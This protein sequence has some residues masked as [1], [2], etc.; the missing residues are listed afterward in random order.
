M[1]GGVIGLCLVTAAATGLTGGSALHAAL[2]VLV[3]ALTQVL[4]G[5]MIWRVVRA[6]DGWW[7]EDVTAG[8]AIGVALAVLAQSAAGT[9]SM[10]WLVWVVPAVVVLVLSAVP[11][12]RRRISTATTAALP[13]WIWPALGLVSLLGLPDIVR[14]F[15]RIPV[16]LNG[17]GATMYPDALFQVALS[18]ELL[19][20]GPTGWPMV[21]GEHLSYPWFTHAWTAQVSS[22][23]GLPLDQTL[24]RLLPI[25]SPLLA[26]GAAAALVLRLRGGPR[27]AVLAG[28]LTLM[29]GYANIFAVPGVA[30]SLNSMSPTLNLSVPLLLTLVAL[31]AQRWSGRA[32]PG[33]AVLVLVLGVVATGTKGSTTPLLIAGC[34]LALVAM[35]VVGRRN[36][37]RPI[38]VDAVLLT[39]SMLLTLKVLLRGSANGLT[40]NPMGASEAT[41]A[42]TMLSGPATLKTTVVV[43]VVTVVFLLAR[44]ATGLVCLLQPGTDRG[45]ADPI[46][47][48]LL[49]SVLAGIGAVLA[50]IQPGR[51]QLYFLINGH[52]LAAVLSALGAG[53]LMA[54]L[55]KDFSGR[56]AIIATTAVSGLALL[57]GPAAL[58]SPLRPTQFRTMGLYALCALVLLVVIVIA[59]NG[60]VPRTVS[61]RGVVLAGLVAMTWTATGVSAAALGW[62]PTPGGTLPRE[63]AVQKRIV[64]PSYVSR[65][66]VEAARFVRARAGRDDV[67]MTDL[68]CTTQ[69]PAA[70]PCESRW[71]TYAAYTEQPMLLEGWG[72]SPTIARRFPGSRESLVAPF[73]DQ[74][75]QRLNDDFYR[76]PTVAAQRELWQRGVRWIVR[77][78]DLG[79]RG[80]LKPYATLELRTPEVTV[81]RMR[82]PK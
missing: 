16:N 37:L 5:A 22:A 28:V 29:G 64:T 63:L 43:A 45:R 59:L 49:G 76:T 55:G 44:A 71:F 8:F 57:V 17:F 3:I 69:A 38:A 80:D 36:L 66:M 27:A 40:I 46:V 54:R 41:L 48:L 70:K 24:Y 42:G 19:H 34:A 33:S 74:K 67:V 25:L 65:D 52:P 18:G 50:F 82:A 72:Y 79:E 31:I 30:S 7:L 20:R 6:R 51:S 61:Q 60:L 26:V 21:Q 9:W 13:R 81:W 14:T 47:W 4:P 39:L 10:P 11:T 56:T 53:V 78:E 62:R 77:D 35:F 2:A 73:W 15:H 1:T 75:L 23:S 58:L 68:H 32:G 12:L